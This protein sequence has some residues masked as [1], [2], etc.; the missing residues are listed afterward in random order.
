MEICGT[1]GVMLEEPLG[2]SDT[3][4]MLPLVTKAVGTMSTGTYPTHV[5]TKMKLKNK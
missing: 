5:R 3:S 2:A 4:L 1:I